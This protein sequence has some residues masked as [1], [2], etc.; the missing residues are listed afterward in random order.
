MALLEMPLNPEK[1]LRAVVAAPGEVVRNAGDDD[2]GDARHERRLAGTVGGV[3]KIGDCP[4][5]S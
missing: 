1:D 2:A 5:P 3:N 4:I